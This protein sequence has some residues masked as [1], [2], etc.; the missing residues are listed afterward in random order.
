MGK[1]YVSIGLILVI[2][3]NHVEGGWLK[4]QLGLE[5]DFSESTVI[6]FSPEERNYWKQQTCIPYFAC[7]PGYFMPTV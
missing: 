4:Q 3:L 1:F 5:H 2:S 6:K 7:P